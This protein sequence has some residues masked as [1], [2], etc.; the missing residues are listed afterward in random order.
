MNKIPLSESAANNIKKA[1]LL[2]RSIIQGLDDRLL[3]IVGPCSIHNS[4]AAIEYGCLLKEYI[5]KMKKEI[6]SDKIGTIS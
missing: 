3:V 4:Q 6:F 1:R 5:N 2:A